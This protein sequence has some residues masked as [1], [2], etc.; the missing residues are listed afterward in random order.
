MERRAFTLMELLV[1]LAVIA[2]LAALLLP[3]ISGSKDKAKRA[4]CTNNLRQINLGIR[5][6]ADDSNDASPNVG[7]NAGVFMAYKEMMKSYV[8]L[9]GASSARDALFACPADIWCYTNHDPPRLLQG[10]HEQPRWDFSSYAFNAGNYSSNFQGIAG[11]KLG[12]I[13]HPS[14]TVM[15]AE[16]PAFWPYSWHHPAREADYI[17]ESHFNNAR[18]VV[19]FVDGHV[20]YIRMYLDTTNTTMGHEEAWQY[21]PPANY[22]YQWS[23]D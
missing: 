15:V 17:N 4:G 6:Y 1:A 19:S 11:R 14:R 9:R 12:S 18:D 10:L 7:T 2:V 21:D 16:A 20:G 13:R 5:L 8:G 3:A 23:G 22:E